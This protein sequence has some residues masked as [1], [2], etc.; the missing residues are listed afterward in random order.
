MS[1]T[2]TDPEISYVRSGVRGPDGSHRQWVDEVRFEANALIYGVPVLDAGL[3]IGITPSNDV[4]SLRLTRID[5]TPLDPI[6]TE[7]SEA[8]LRDS[9]ASHVSG[10]TDAQLETVAVA[11]RRPVYV[12]DPQSFS[13]PVEPRYL[14]RYSLLTNDAEAWTTV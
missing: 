11:E 1:P 8:A 13:G 14:V 6:V 10:T 5:Y 2:A 3:R 7:A 9:F 4:S 12:L